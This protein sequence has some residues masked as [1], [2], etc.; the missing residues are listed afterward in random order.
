MTTAEKIILGVGFL[1]ML[2]IGF[3]ARA[4]NPKADDLVCLKY[5]DTVILK[6]QIAALQNTISKD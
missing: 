4:D 2:F 5:K 3:G 1:I 6:K